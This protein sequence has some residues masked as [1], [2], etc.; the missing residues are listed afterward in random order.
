MKEGD[1]SDHENLW[2][3]DDMVGEVMGTWVWVA[4]EIERKDG[5]MD[6]TVKGP[7][8]APYLHVTR[9]MDN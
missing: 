5:T 7:D 4:L 9:Y 3:L 2:R 1:C 6:L 8:L